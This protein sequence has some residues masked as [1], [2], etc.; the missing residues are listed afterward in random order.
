M[1][2]CSITLPKKDLQTLIN[3]L[4]L[5]IDYEEDIIDSYKTEY[6]FKDGHALRKV[7][8]ENLPIVKMVEKNIA[9]FHDVKT[10]LLT[11]FKGGIIQHEKQKR[12]H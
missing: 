4:I 6:F 1:N 3:A 8:K 7:A 2:I 10:Q 12:S 9:R 11:V 5:A